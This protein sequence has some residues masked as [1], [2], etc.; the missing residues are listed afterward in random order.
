ME[1]VNPERLLETAV[2]SMLRTLDPY[3]EYQVCRLG[4]SRPRQSTDA[5]ANY[6]ENMFCS[7]SVWSSLPLLLRYSFRTFFMSCRVLLRSI[8]DASDQRAHHVGH[9]RARTHTHTHTHNTHNHTHTH[10]RYTHAAKVLR[11]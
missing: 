9:A 8:A 6:V 4:S 5:T 11:T 10:T 1:E 2:V 3:T 7:V